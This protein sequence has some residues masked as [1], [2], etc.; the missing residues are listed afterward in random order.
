MLKLF[1]NWG[2]ARRLQLSIGIAAGLV[3][4]TTVWLNYQANRAQLETQTNANALAEIRDAA[5]GLDDFIARVGMLPRSIAIHQRSW[6]PNPDPRIAPFLRE[7]LGVTPLDEAYGCYMAYESM[8][9]RD[10]NACPAIHRKNW[11]VLTPVLY[12]YHDTSQ[13]WYVGPKQSRAFYVTEPYFD[14]GAG[15]ISMVSLTVPVFD[16][17]S[18]FVGVAGLDLS[19]DR[20]RAMVQ[21]IRLRTSSDVG[22]RTMANEYAALI[23]RSGKV[24]AHPDEQLMLRKGFPGADLV[25][26]PGGPTV[27]AQRE[28]FTSV[29]KDGQPRRLY[30]ATSPLTGWKVVLSISEDAINVPVRQLALRSM[31]IG[32]LGLLVMILIISILARRLAQ[33]LLHLT[34][35]AAAI[36]QGK[37]HDE[38]LGNLPRRR[39]EL[40]GLGRSFQKMARE[41]HVREQRL[42]DLNQNLERT[43][44]QRT[45]QLTTHAAELEK[46]NRLSQERATLESS[47]SALNTSLRGNLTTAQ[48]AERALSGI[49]EFLGSPVGALFVVEEDGLL[50]R[51]ATYSYPDDDDLPKSFAIGSGIIG[52]SAQ[53]RRP[54]LSEPGPGKLLVQFGFG[55]VTPAHI[56]AYPLLS[57]E[58]PVGVVE[59]CLFKPLTDTQTVWMEKVS[60]MVANA[61]RFALESE[62]RRKAEQLLRETEQFFRSV[63]EL[64]PDGLMVVDAD[65]IIRLANAQSER[66]FGYTRDEIVGQPIEIVV[67]ETVRSHHPALRQ[68]FLRSPQMREMGANRELVAQRKDGSVFPVAIGLSV[69]PAR[70]G[71]GVQVA[72]SI[73]DI[74]ERKDQENALKLAKAKA[75]EATEMKS[76]FLA[77]MSHEIRT[78]MNA[79]IGLSH[80]ALK[81][82]LNAKQRDYV[83][84]VHNAGTS[85]LAVI[86]D[87]LDF[88][89]IEAGKL[90][91]ET[92]D[93][94]IDEVI[95]S[96]TTL[97]AQKAH[98]KGLEYLAEVGRTIPEQLRGDPLRLGQVLTNLV[99][100]A[101]KFTEHGEIRLKIELVE[102][103]GEKVHLKFSV[104]D[105]GIGMTREQVAKLFQPFTQADMSTTRKHGGTGLGLTI[106]RRLVELMGGRIWLESEPGAGTTFFFTVWLEVGATHGSGKVI[107]ERLTHLRALVVDDNPAA[108]EILQEPLSRLV[109][110]V[111]TV[112]SGP[113][114]LDAIRHHASNEP[115][116]IVFMDWR[117]PGMD[118]L[119]AS[120]FIKNDETLSSKPAIV[121]VTAFGR[122]EVREEAERLQLDGFL[123]KPVTKSMLIDALVN[124]FAIPTDE[125]GI[126]PLA[127]AAETA[128]LK[129]LRVL[130]AEDNEINQQI[131]VEL[132][133]GAGATVDI[134][135]HG[136]EAV[137]K[138]F[139]GSSPPAYDV[140]LMDLQMPEMDGYQA[141][142][143]IRSDA[144]FNR[145]PIIAMTAHATIEERQRC[146]AAGMNDHIAKPIDPALLFQTLGRH[147]KPTAPPESSPA[148]EPLVKDK[149]APADQSIPSIQGLDVED[150][151]KRVANNRQLYLKLLR[152]FVEQQ[153]TAPAQITDAL[154]HNDLA[155]AERLAHTV[156]GVAGSLGARSVQN[157]AGTLEKAIA[158]KTPTSG[159]A[160]LIQEFASILDDLV[161]R[162]R[163]EL[164]EAP[165]SRQPDAPTPPVSL[166]QAKKVLR[167]MAAHLSNFDP[168]AG[169]CLETHRNVF[170]SL[171]PEAA[172]QS[173]EQQVGGFAFAEALAQLQQAAKDK[174]LLDEASL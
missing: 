166:D 127:G 159:L 76:M 10:T 116:D 128:P 20:I 12:D 35:T 172:F 125:T 6:G 58:T 81:T 23:S 64:A 71:Q 49:I 173:F 43:V 131:A 103:T 165:Q 152:Q 129:G 17:G 111:E 70:Q 44:E 82:P 2:I 56:V 8:N 67:P 119:Q 84:K 30:W 169:D 62:D 171:L 110:R 113:E 75:E 77:N 93:F 87:I 135:D 16:Q 151:L 63:L 153:S 31:T 121:L 69:L 88:S 132:L 144:R 112:A 80:L 114:A 95:S 33:P 142:T 117:M 156:K 109:N 124:I 118:G 147:F 21:S 61:L 27:V 170:R 66:L 78:P 97:T 46:L 168:A 154:A 136:G 137:E 73:R 26:L 122:E 134:A 138:L 53:S 108:R 52:Q 9:W 42:A 65:G 83:S 99:N 18:N 29:I 24:I 32:G 148:N 85:L 72:V 3:L 105:T 91:L 60:E 158:T 115:Y 45:A 50:H 48:V 133:Q 89:K 92:T 141:T 155:L 41:I 150:G 126:T 68:S 51:L 14:E 174:G 79:I 101:V 163:H 104:R 123:I 167:E 47:L 106:S 74:S 15:D 28:G 5:R 130:L 25:S 100:N 59:L 120:R 94:Q 143:K 139:S 102:R 38:M 55:P 140:V 22:E 57:S 164:P 36:E 157:V 54:I 98:D 161:G 7:L 39:D 40:G 19:L 146:L 4:G 86:N 149:I 90:D 96:V 162:L 107:P 37:F 160:P 13:E 1:S 145:I 11:P 34:R